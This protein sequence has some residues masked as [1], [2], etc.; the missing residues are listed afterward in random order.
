MAATSSPKVIYIVASH[1]SGSTLL[2]NLLGEMPGFLS[3]GE[4]RFLFQAAAAGG[5][6]PCGCGAPVRECRVWAPVLARLAEE[7]F[8]PAM[9]HALQQQFSPVRHSWRQLPQLLR[10]G[11]QA[12]PVTSYGRALGQLYRAVVDVS[13]ADVVVD[14]SKEPTDAA[15]V[16]RLTGV[17]AALVHVVRDPRGVV[18][19]ARERADPRF[20]ED[21]DPVE[22]PD[23]RLSVKVTGSWVIDQLATAAL[24]SRLAT[25]SVRIRYEDF[26]A[27]PE[28]TLRKVVSR[29]GEPWPGSPVDAARHVHFSVNHTVSGNSSRFRQGPTELRLDDRWMRRLPTLDRR[30]STAL[31]LPLLARFG[32]LRRRR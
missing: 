31:A 14:A 5:S 26:V 24:L 3:V 2:G 10:K 23:P 7:G 20:R 16:A 15:V 21:R 13:G 8:D 17:R 29:I 25:P 28:T 6:H 12:P 4:L 18:L 27:Q 19:S 1:R 30:V 11:E 22:R 9:V 32:Y